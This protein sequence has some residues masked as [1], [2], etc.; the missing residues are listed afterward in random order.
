MNYDNLDIENITMEDWLYF[1]FET[2]KKPYLKPYSLRNIEQMI[3][4]HT[5]AFLKKKRVKDI[6]VFDVEL[7]LMKIPNGRTRAYARQVWGSSF[8]KAQ[9]YDIITKNVVLLTDTVKYKKN[10]GRSLTRAELDAFLTAIEG[11]RL[12][13]LYLFYLFTG[14]RRCEALSLLWSDVLKEE[15]LIRIRG[16]KTEG[17]Y[18]YIFLSNDLKNILEGQRLQNQKDIGTRFENP[19]PDKVFNYSPYYISKMFATLCPGHHLHDLRH[20]F[21]T[22]CAEC[23]INVSV[24]QQLV[25][26]A[27]AN[28]TLNV[29]T[30]VMDDF[31][32]KEA[33]KFTIR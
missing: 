31:K 6:T 10:H 24:C 9:K 13:W 23:G 3:R 33:A 27:T 32:R 17:S 30:H 28:M 26:H 16:T 1:W 14:T 2:F 18:R 22:R 19:Y 12:K 4:I 5:P 11:N 29:Y 7:A 21:I 20:N 15:E 8:L 25:G